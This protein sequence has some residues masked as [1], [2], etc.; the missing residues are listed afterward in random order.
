MKQEL[1]LSWLAIISL[2]E[3][4]V[5]YFPLI[6]N[7]IF[8]VKTKTKKIESHRI[9][10]KKIQTQNLKTV[11]IRKALLIKIQ[12]TL[13]K[14]LKAKKNI[15][16]NTKKSNDKSI[17]NENIKDKKQTK[18]SQQTDDVRNENYIG[19]PVADSKK[20]KDKK[21]GWWNK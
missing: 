1:I 3:K 14:K 20:T 4:S 19:A 7:Q 9:R 18:K 11:Q 12:K 15:N 16:K 6:Q 10:I 2:E 21:T 5:R 8:L 17:L 13:A